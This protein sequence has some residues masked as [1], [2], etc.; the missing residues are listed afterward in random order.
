MKRPWIFLVALS[1]SGAIG[2]A[3]TQTHSSHLLRPGTSVSGL[4]GVRV[5]AP[6][7]W[8]EGPATGV[9]V[10]ITRLERD[11]L[12]WPIDPR[13]S[14]SLPIYR[15]Q[16]E[17]PV[18]AGGGGWFTVSLPTGGADATYF[19]PWRL[20]TATFDSD[21]PGGNPTDWHYDSSAI[22]SAG[23]L[24]FEITGFTDDTHLFTAIT[25]DEPR[26]LP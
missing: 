4:D 18:L 25:L 12:E 5:S 8:R 7:Q 14:L 13:V 10:T 20:S 23:N 9:Q 1:C 26:T 11:E 17:L 22:F 24:S 19:A 15:V 3:P 6:T 16:T 21:G 2:C